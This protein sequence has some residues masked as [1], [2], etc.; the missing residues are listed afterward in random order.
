[1]RAGKYFCVIAYDTPSAKRRRRI[2]KALEQYGKRINYS[3][4]ECMLTPSQEMTLLFELKSLVIKGKDQVA[5]YRICV[6]CF[7]KIIYIPEKREHS[8][9][10]KIIG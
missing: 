8:E 6:N 9:T 7:T 4:Y 5:V 1:M 3:V 2:V 10:V